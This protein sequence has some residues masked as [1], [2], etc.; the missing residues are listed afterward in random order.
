VLASLGIHVVRQIGPKAF[1]VE[2]PRY[3]PFTRM[4]K[5]LAAHGV[6]F[7]EIAG[8]T[9]VLLSAVMPDGAVPSLRDGT[10]L[11][12]APVLTQ[13][14]MQRVVIACEAASLQKLIASLDGQEVTIEHVYDY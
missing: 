12:A 6:Q 7:V 2:L 13:P 4:A 8:N 5:A 1:I 11:F 3:Q 9:Q 10:V 14:G